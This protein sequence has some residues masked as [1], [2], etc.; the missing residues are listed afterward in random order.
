MPSGAKPLTA[1]L[2]CQLINLDGSDARLASAT[3]QLEA[4]KLPFT[5]VAAVDGRVTAPESFER[6]D[7]ERTRRW[8]GR[9]LSGGEIGCYLSHIACAE[10]FLDSGAEYG[11]SLEDD[12]LLKPAFLPVLEETLTWLEA[13]QPDWHMVNLGRAVKRHG[14][15]VL[16]LAGTTLMRAHHFPDTTTAILWSR[17]GAEAFLAQAGAIFAPV[18]HALRL[19]NTAHDLGFAYDV[20]PITTTGA[21]SDIQNAPRQRGT[22]GKGLGYHLRKQR[23]LWFLKRAARRNQSS[24]HRR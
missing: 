15:P 20:A 10:R 12:L 3:A 23:R 21:E 4:A 16:H 18:D 13:H 19:W 14:T 1:N 2:L 17:T 9:R 6:Y 8:M 24:L 7:A 11:L 5:R 22:S